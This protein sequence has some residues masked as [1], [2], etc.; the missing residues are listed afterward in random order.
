MFIVL[1]VICTNTFIDFAKFTSFYPILTVILLYNI[2]NIRGWICKYI[3]W[4]GQ[5]HRGVWSD[6]VSYCSTIFD[7]LG[8][9][10]QIY[11]YIHWFGQ[12]YMLLSNICVILGVRSPKSKLVEFPCIQSKPKV[13][14]FPAG[15]NSLKKY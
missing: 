4:F 3:Y 12:I 2:W 5:I 6:I 9:R 11:K 8:L 10:G 7:I 13:W 15:S 14:S 1:Q